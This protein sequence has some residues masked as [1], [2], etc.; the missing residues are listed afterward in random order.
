MDWDG[1]RDRDGE[2]DRDRGRERGRYDESHSNC[3][4]REVECEK[5]IHIY[6]LQPPP[7]D[8]DPSMDEGACMR[9]MRRRDGHVESSSSSSSSSS[10]R[11]D[12]SYGI[13]GEGDEAACVGQKR[14]LVLSAVGHTSATGDRLILSALRRTIGQGGAGSASVPAS[15]SVPVYQGGSNRTVLESGDVAG[16]ADQEDAPD[17]VPV[18]PLQQVVTMVALEVDTVSN[19]E[20]SALRSPVMADALKQ[21]SH[22]REALLA[23]KLKNRKLLRKS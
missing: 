15:V 8:L 22:M 16:N 1:G 6:A 10:S 20:D 2:R 9:N 23:T 21:E 19:V 18:E 13:E 4:P 12:Q 3:R 14:R 11:D 5:G 7:W 17:L